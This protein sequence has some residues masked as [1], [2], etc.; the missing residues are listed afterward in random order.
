MYNMLNIDGNLVVTIPGLLYNAIER[1]V[2][3]K[4]SVGTILFKAFTD[5]LKY[6]NKQNKDNVVLMGAFTNYCIVLKKLPGFLIKLGQGTGIR[7]KNM[8]NMNVVDKDIQKIKH[9][10]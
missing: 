9:L 3:G 5:Y 1:N 6:M 10:L 2:Y 4:T 8:L 7:I